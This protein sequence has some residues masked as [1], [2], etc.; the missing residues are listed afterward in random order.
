MAFGLQVYN[1]SG[2]IVLDAGSS[3]FEFIETLELASGS[4]GSKTYNIGPGSII[5]V[6]MISQYGGTVFS[7]DTDG[8][9]TVSWNIP[10][11]GYIFKASIYRGELL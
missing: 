5:M 7:L 10:A 9:N 11:N 2:S 4:V 8:Y 6:V 3:P 1:D